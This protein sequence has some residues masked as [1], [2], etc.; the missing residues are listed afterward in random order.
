MIEFGSDF[1][2]IDG[3]HGQRNKLS[4]YYPQT[5]NYADGRQALIHLYHTQ[6]WQCLWIPEYFCYDVIASL[7]QYGLNLMYYQ[8]WPDCH[9]DGN[10]LENIQRSGRFRTTDAVLRVNYF[11]MRSYRGAGKL[12]VATVVEDHTHD[13]IGDWAMRSTADWCIASLRK[14]LPI[15]EGGILW[16]PKGFNLPLVPH[17]LPKNESIAKIRWDAMRLK[18]RYLAG[19]AVEKEDFRKGFIGTEEFFDIAPIC[20]LDMMS[21]EYLKS[22]NIRGW[23]DK[24]RENWN[25][26]KDIKKYG[27]KVICPEGKGCYPFSVVLMF[28]NPNERER[29]RKALISH[30]IYPAI[31]WNVP[32][33]ADGEVLKFSR[34]M[35]SVHC[36][37]RYTN[38][39]ILEMKS[40]IESIL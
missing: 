21:Q 1:H 2:H 8:D 22:F 29:V 13:L 30:R 16:S 40:I 4:D 7:K 27:V 32:I 15:P 5:S 23:Y 36:D 33:D 9:C 20:A 3:F 28:D 26:L 37:A 12:S 25:I 34:N 35:L 6:G 10:T 39:E 38:N 19:E 17:S 18:T 24:K 31:L 14:T 11:G